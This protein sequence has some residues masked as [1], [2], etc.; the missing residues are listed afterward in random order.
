ME[1]LHAEYE[2]L[3]T[4]GQVV[5]IVTR[6]GDVNQRSKVRCFTRQS[7]AEVMMDYIERPDTNDSFV[8]F[9]PG[10]FMDS[11]LLSIYILTKDECT[12]PGFFFILHHTH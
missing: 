7:S 5:A 11:T 3:E 10:M 12:C 1:F 4:E 6:S 9:A 8:E 2:V